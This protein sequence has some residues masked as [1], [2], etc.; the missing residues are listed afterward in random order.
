LVIEAAMGRRE[1]ITIFGPD[2][3]TPDGSCI[4]DYVHVEDLIAARAWHRDEAR[5]FGERRSVLL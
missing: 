5:N 2:Y 3:P 4:R 1:V